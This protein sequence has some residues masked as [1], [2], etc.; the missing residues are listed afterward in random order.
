MNSPNPDFFL[1]TPVKESK[2]KL[3]PEQVIR[4]FLRERNWKQSE[5]AQKIGLSRQA[6]NNY[7]RGFWVFP[8]SIKIKIAQAFE[9]DSSI[10]WDLEEGK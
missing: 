8:T 3:S 5:L 4:S 9:I 7:L 1:N 10:I 2:T 6:L